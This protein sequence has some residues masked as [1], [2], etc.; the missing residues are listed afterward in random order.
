MVEKGEMAARLGGW[1]AATKSCA[2]PGYDSPIMT[3]RSAHGCAATV[4]VTS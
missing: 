2:I 4:S 3:T 1:V